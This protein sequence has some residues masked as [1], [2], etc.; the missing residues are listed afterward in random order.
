VPVEQ[1]EGA[2]RPAGPGGQHRVRVF[3]PPRDAGGGVASGQS[4]VGDRQHRRRVPA[5]HYPPT[6]DGVRQLRQQPPGDRGGAGR[7][8]ARRF[9]GAVP[10]PNRVD[11][12]VGG[13]RATGQPQRP[14]DLLAQLG[15][16]VFEQGAGLGGGQPAATYAGAH[17]GRPDRRLR[18]R[19]GRH[20]RLP[21][22]GHRGHGDGEEPFL[23]AAG[24]QGS[25]P[26][27][28]LAGGGQPPGPRRQG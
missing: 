8:Q 16:G 21:V 12:G 3:P 10:L 13:L 18:I 19:E 23:G 24:T 6:A 26:H 7:Q 5:R 17:G 4:G 11:Q 2:V 15:R 14:V 9:D 1:V 25:E 22:A 28:Q 27:R 20:H